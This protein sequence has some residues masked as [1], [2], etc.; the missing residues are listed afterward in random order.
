MAFYRNLKYV[1]TDSA[2]ISTVKN[3]STSVEIVTD[4]DR[5]EVAFGP[6]TV[7]AGGTLTVSGTGTLTVINYNTFITNN[8]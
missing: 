1:S 6:I 7:E 2:I 5:Y 8:V 3:I 4:E